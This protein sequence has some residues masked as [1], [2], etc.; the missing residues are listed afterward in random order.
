MT[1]LQSVCLDAEAQ[2]D[3]LAWLKIIF[4]ESRS[5][6]GLPLGIDVGSCSCH[7]KAE[8]RCSTCQDDRVDPGSP[9]ESYPSLIERIDTTVF[10]HTS[11]RVHQESEAD[12]SP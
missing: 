10:R 2:N 8:E 11:L 1:H 12:P 7:G 4:D 3:Q 5:G 9:L 6:D